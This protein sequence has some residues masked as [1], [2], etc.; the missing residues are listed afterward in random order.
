ML[1]PSDYKTKNRLYNVENQTTT[2]IS[3][4]SSLESEQYGTER[5]LEAAQRSLKAIKE[6]LAQQ[7][8][9]RETQT[10]IEMN[11]LL[12]DY[13]KQLLSLELTLAKLLTERTTEHPDVKTQMSQMAAVKAK[14]TNEIEKTFSSQNINRNSYY[15]ELISTYY[16]TEIN[17]IKN[18]AIKNIASRQ[19][20]KMNA[21]LK[22][23]TMKDRKLTHL[24]KEMDNLRSTYSS[25]FLNL[26]AAK[27]AL[28]TD[29]TNTVV[30]QP[31][32]LFK[33]LKENLKFP[34]EKK[35]SRIVLAIIAGTIL[36]FSL[37]FL[38]EYLDDSLWSN[39]EIENALNSKVV[40]NIPKVN[41]HNLN[42]VKIED[43]LLADSIHNLLANIKLFKGNGCGKVISI[44]SSIKGEGKSTLAALI[45]GTM[46]HHGKKV[47]LIDGN[48]RYPSLHNI[49]NL[50]SRTGLA[51]YL[52][53]DIKIQEMKCLTSIPNLDVITAGTVSITNPQKHIDS[54][55]FF[56]LIQTLT[57]DYD[58][59]LFDTPA[60]VNGS[61]ALLISKHAQDIL[62][63][64]EQGKTPIQKAKEFMVAIEMANIKVTG[65]ILNKVYKSILLNF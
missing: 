19:I 64:I 48:M 11:P 40:Y 43:S 51:N 50:P 20:S 61:D 33:N 57:K 35:G 27:S 1:N 56:E 25:L 46:A 58:N 45:S 23:L 10:T 9:Y 59:V 29:I 65:V 31:P 53:S 52:L 30:I 47:V 16:N 4:A 60:F 7:Q 13:K 37:V 3:S 34:P 55:K 36:G 28:C 54:N 17:I 63:I 49:F 8:E 12:E 44:V 6:T 24:S 38:L 41:V 5:T 39:Q 42:I 21:K 26:E 62:F 18:T 15:D 22:I 32:L 14:I 2:L